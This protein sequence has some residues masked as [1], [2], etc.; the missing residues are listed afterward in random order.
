[1]GAGN[2]GAWNK[3]KKNYG[4]DSIVYF[5][6]SGRRERKNLK[7]EDVFSFSETMFVVSLLILEG[8]KL[9]RLSKLKFP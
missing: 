9:S 3:E 1:M 4:N 6:C 2:G 7:R 8:V 5:F